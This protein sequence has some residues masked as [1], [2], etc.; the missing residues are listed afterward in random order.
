MHPARPGVA[1]QTWPTTQ[2]VVL[3]HQR[4]FLGRSRG[5]QEGFLVKYTYQVGGVVY[6]NDRRSFRQTDVAADGFSDNE[7]GRRE[8]NER[9]PRGKPCTVHYNP[10]NPAESCLEPGAGATAFVLG[11]ISAFLLGLG[12][13]FL[14]AALRGDTPGSGVNPG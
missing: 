6:E 1:S 8:L 5:Y 7:E 9:Y 4:C 14:V 13:L 12:T 3:A 10:D 2:G 11:A